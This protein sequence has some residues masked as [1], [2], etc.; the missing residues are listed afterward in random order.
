[1]R[2]LL[3]IIVVPIIATL[4][5]FVWLISKLL[6]CS[7]FIFGLTSS[8][9][10]ILGIAVMFAYSFQNGFVLLAIAFVVSPIGLPMVAAWLLGKFQEINFALRNFVRS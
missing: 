3:K 8:L 7:A 4:T 2:L 6:Y 5:I 10:A 1:M 9:I